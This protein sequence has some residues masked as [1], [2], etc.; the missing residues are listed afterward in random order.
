MNIQQSLWNV[1][2]VDDAPPPI[3]DNAPRVGAPVINNYG[4]RGYIVAACAPVNSVYLLGGCGGLQPVRVEYEIAFP[5]RLAILAA[6]TVAP[7]VATARRAGMLDCID[8]EAARAAASDGQTARRDAVTVAKA[9]ADDAREVF[10]SEAARRVPAWAE[11][12]IVAA[13]EHDDCDSY[14]D[15][16]N[17]KT[18]RSVILGFSRHC[19]DLFPELRQA[20]ALFPDTAELTDAPASAEHREKYSMGG[21]YYLKLGNRYTTGWRVH[22]VRLGTDK[23]RSMPVADWLPDAPAPIAPAAATATA[24]GFTIARHPHTKLGFDMFICSNAERVERETF[25]AQRDQ[26]KAAGGWYSRPWGRTPGGFAFKLEADA[27]AFVAA[28][29]GAAAPMVETPDAT[30][31]PRTVAAVAGLADRFRD[32]AD[33][34]ESE[35][36]SK[37]GDR[38]R[39]TPK[40]QRQAAE[41]R[42][43]GLH[44]KRVQ[45]AL[46]GLA[47]AHDAGAVP[48]ALAAVRTKSIINDLAR[49][50]I[51]RSGRYYDAGFDTG[52]PNS[53]TPAALA[54][55]DIIGG[56]DVAAAQAEQLRRK[57]DSLQFANIPGYFASPPAVVSRMI[58]A[59]EIGDCARVLE[60]SAGSGNILDAVRLAYPSATLCAYE[61]HESL[62]EILLTKGYALAGS[63]FMEA[64]AGG[65]DRILMNPPFERGQDMQHVRK[66]FELLTPGGRLVA[67]MSPGPFFRQNSAA[68]EFRAWLDAVGGYHEPLPSGSFKAAGTGVETVLVTID[69]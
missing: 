38:R 64:E 21:G 63:D 20:A 12:V 54:L 14:T 22:K 32:M 7:Y 68:T 11:S 39:N 57:I 9:A 51:E 23:A 37:F 52:K 43:D 66:A 6:Q 45:K 26:A 34:L 55:W 19:R 10:Y 24:G 61:R 25:D 60:P 41:A 18:S 31:A 42:N 56:R 2:A 36:V 5:D 59:A 33:G 4:T 49:A 1:P 62:R 69:R 44:L 67:V 28:C 47:A 46:R 15:Y 8:I 29:G 3:V 27:V 13:L 35:I 48:P 30:S 50:K 17:V 58:D 53:D 65:F 16:Y 40:Q